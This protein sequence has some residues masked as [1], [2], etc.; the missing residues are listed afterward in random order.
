[1]KGIYSCLDVVIK[2]YSFH[3]NDFL[4]HFSSVSCWVSTLS[5]ILLNPPHT[6]DKEEAMQ[7]KLLFFFFFWFFENHLNYS[8]DRQNITWKLWNLWPETWQLKNIRILLKFSDIIYK[9]DNQKCTFY[10]YKIIIK[11][12]GEFWRKKK[13]A[14]MKLHLL[15][16]IYAGTSIRKYPIKKKY[17]DINCCQK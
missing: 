17:K 3:N 15:D 8:I 13:G 16:M 2:L 5:P 9:P 10:R 4:N 7:L 12:K 6:K 1:M 11:M 14:W